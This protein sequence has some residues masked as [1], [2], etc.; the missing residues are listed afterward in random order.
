MGHLIYLPDY[1]KV[2]TGDPLLPVCRAQAKG[3]EAGLCRQTPSAWLEGIR[4]GLGYRVSSSRGNA[5]RNFPVDCMRPA[6]GYRVLKAASFLLPEATGPGNIA[7]RCCFKICTTSLTTDDSPLTK[8]NDKASQQ[9]PEVL[10]LLF[11]P[12]WHP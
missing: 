9:V 8:N 5:E 10:I 7:Q 4:G 11:I 12:Q 3:R 1:A 6:H 2:A